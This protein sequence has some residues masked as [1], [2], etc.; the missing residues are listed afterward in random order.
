MY[1]YYTHTYIYVYTPYVTRHT[2]Y[3]NGQFD[4]TFLKDRVVL[5]D[6]YKGGGKASSAT[7][8]K[9]YDEIIRFEYFKAQ[10]FI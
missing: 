1:I 6:F 9:V 3:F 7:G 8:I 10:C 2:L 4:L 5:R